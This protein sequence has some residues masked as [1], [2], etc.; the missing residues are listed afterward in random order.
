[1]QSDEVPLDVYVNRL[2]AENGRLRAELATAHND[3]LEVAAKACE[4]YGSS[5]FAEKVRALNREGG[6]T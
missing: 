5:Y 2:R 6:G 4:R 3:A 1:M